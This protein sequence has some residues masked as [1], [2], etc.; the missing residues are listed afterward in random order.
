MIKE[1]KARQRQPDGSGVKKSKLRGKWHERL[2]QTYLQNKV[3]QIVLL[4][5]L[6]LSSLLVAYLGHLMDRA[7][8]P[9]IWS[10][11]EQQTSEAGAITR[12]GSGGYKQP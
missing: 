5:L 2:L 6:W 9:L 4:V 10:Q 8:T 7:G 1:L 3:R 12:E 11:I